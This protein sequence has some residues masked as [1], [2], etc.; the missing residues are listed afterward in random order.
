MG[1]VVCGNGLAEIKLILKVCKDLLW[2]VIKD[3]FGFALGMHHIVDLSMVKTRNGSDLGKGKTLPV[4]LLY[5]VTVIAF[6]L[7]CT[8][9]TKLL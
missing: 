1:K 6:S 5:V 7:L 4:E 8:T 2:T 3:D 9:V